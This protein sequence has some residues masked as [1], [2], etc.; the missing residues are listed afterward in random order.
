MEGVCPEG[1]G[2]QEMER[3]EA[4]VRSAFIVDVV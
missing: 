2:E 4:F 1:G 3:S